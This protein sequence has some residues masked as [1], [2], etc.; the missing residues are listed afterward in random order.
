[1]VAAVA[2]GDEQV[3]KDVRKVTRLGD[4]YVPTD[5]RQLCGLLLHTCYMGTAN[6]SAVTRERAASLADEL[7]AHH[8]PSIIDPM[9]RGVMQVFKELTKKEP[10]YKSE[11][12]T[13]AEDVALQNIQ[14]RSR[15]VLSYLL[16]Q[17]L[18]WTRGRSGFL[19]VLGSANVDEALRG[20]MTKYD[21]SAADVNPIGGISKAD[22]K[23]FLVHAAAH[24]GYPS[25][26]AV[27]EAPPTA[28]LRPLKGGEIEQ[29]DEEDMGMTYDE[30]GVFGRLRK[31][32]AAPAPRAANAPGPYALRTPPAALTCPTISPSPDRALRPGLNVPEASQPVAGQQLR[33]RGRCQ[34]ACASTRRNSPAKPLTC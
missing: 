2:A 7:G 28:E 16:A 24:L 19:L 1:M 3:L 6:S 20:Y 9:I 17:L 21:C 23:R 25:L 26:R 10:R 31:V 15:M 11:G 8:T 12:G 32:Q 29:T 18:P 4:D 22:L 33:R 30:L 34:G 27:V 13:H 5:P 14:A